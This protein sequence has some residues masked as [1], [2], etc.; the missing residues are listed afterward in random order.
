MARRLMTARF[1]DAGDWQPRWQELVKG[2]VRVH[3]AAGEQQLLEWL[4]RPGEPRVLAFVNAHAMNAAAQSRQFFNS[5]MSA[6]LLLRDGLGMAILLRLLNQRPGRNLNGTDLIPRILARYE[7]ATVALFGTQDPYLSRARAVVT[8]LIAPGAHCVA[9]HGFLDTSRY[10]RLAAAH[11]PAII[12][13]GMGMPRQE[14][15]AGVLRAAL[16]FPCLI[17]CGGA[18]IDFLGDKSPRAPVWVRRAGLEWAFRLALEPRRLF[19]RY[20]IGNPLF[21]ARALKLAARSLRQER[22]AAA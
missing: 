3:S 22:G 12:V 1:A 15:V 4:V 6:D 8:S 14:E 13:L 21:V 2:V 5:L 19:K 10:L 16:G 7:G 18:I 17:I 11:R 20:V 9:A